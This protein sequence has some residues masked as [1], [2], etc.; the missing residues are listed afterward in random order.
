MNKPVYFFDI[1]GTITHETAGWDYANRT[2]RIDVIDKM[3]Q[4]AVTGTIVLWTARLD[5]DREVTVQWLKKHNVPYAYIIMEKPFW[6]VYICD[7]SFNVEEWLANGQ[8]TK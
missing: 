4:I 8:N 3:Y 6:D 2:P 7:K 5:C 1:D